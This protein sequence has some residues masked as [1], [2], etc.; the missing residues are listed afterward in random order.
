MKSGKQ[1]GGFTLLEM[2]V[3]LVIIGLV[4][5]SVIVLPP[6]RSRPSFGFHS[7]VSA[8]IPNST[9]STRPNATSARPGRLV[10]VVATF[11]SFFL[12]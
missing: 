6:R 5:V 11:V 12:A 9:T 7:M 1:Q 8:M 10:V 2:I 4:A 3:V